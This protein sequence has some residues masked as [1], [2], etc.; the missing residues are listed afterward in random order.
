MGQMVFSVSG[1]P[2]YPTLGTIAGWV[3]RLLPAG[4]AVIVFFVLS[5]YVLGLGLSRDA[6]FGRF[7]TRRL[8][9]ILPAL[10]LSGIVTFLMTFN[11]SAV[12]Q[13]V[14]FT[15]WFTNVFAKPSLGDLGRNLILAKVNVNAVTW[16]IIPEIVCSL[17]LPLLAYV[18][19]QT[20]LAGHLAIL[21]AL[22]AIG[23]CAG[24]ASAQYLF[25][26]YLGFFGPRAIAPLMSDRYA[27]YA[28]AIVGLALLYLGQGFGPYSPAMR[29]CCAVGA[30][31]LIGALVGRPMTWQ[32]LTLRPLRFL[33][34]V[35]YSFYLLHLPV[36]FMLANM[37]ARFSLQLTFQTNIAIDV[38]S[39]VLALG[40]AAISYRFIETPGIAVGRKI[41]AA[42]SRPRDVIGPTLDPPIKGGDFART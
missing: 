37:A 31:V 35:S 8:C 41:S 14:N 32:W 5:G 33:G 10:W 23:W 20:K 19:G 12:F 36:L 21:I 29:T 18:H 11:L 6:N 38:L 40:F 42:L 24:D 7:A 30:A 1:G 3:T 26:F 9:R 15:E 22:A 25:C 28:G 27:S 4:A 2:S 34:R 17:L 13:I 16:T 39:I